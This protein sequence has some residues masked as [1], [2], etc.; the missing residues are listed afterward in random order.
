MKK[1]PLNYKAILWTLVWLI[2]TLM[3]WDVAFG[4]Y[5]ESEHHAGDILVGFGIVFLVIGI[6]LYMKFRPIYILSQ[7]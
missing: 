6:I 3:T 4:S 5:G 7:K 1:C 2:P